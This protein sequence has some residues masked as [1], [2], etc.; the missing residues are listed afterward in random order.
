KPFTFLSM[1]GKSSEMGAV[2]NFR[3][4]KKS[5]W[6]IVAV[7]V[8]T[9]ITRLGRILSLIIGFTDSGDF[10]GVCCER[11]GIIDSSMIAI[12]AIHEVIFFLYMYF[13]YIPG[14]VKELS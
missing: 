8:A 3:L 9:L 14:C 13:F 6:S 12:T 11:A 2:L 5:V 7:Y 10:L 4:I 1:A